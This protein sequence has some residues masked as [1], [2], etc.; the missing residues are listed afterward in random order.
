M[1]IRKERTRLQNRVRTKRAANYN[2][3]DLAE[4]SEEERIS[5]M[6]KESVRWKKNY[7]MT[8]WK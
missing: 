5:Y 7:R 8:R 4:K 6:N 3:E 2:S 1:R